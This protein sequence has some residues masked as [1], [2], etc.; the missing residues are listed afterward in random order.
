MTVWIFLLVYFLTFSFLVVTHSFLILCTDYR[1]RELSFYLTYRK[2]GFL[3]WTPEMIFNFDIQYSWIVMY[4]N[5]PSDILL[6]IRKENDLCCFLLFNSM[7]VTFFLCPLVLFISFFAKV[8]WMVIG[9]YTCYIIYVK[10][11]LVRISSLFPPCAFPGQTWV[12]RVGSKY[13]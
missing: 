11:K 6:N 1:Y 12:F 4:F 8:E 13:P 7:V 2:F 10:V 5:M 9:V 3:S